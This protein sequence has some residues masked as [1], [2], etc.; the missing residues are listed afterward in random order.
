MG[1]IGH[2]LGGGQCGL[3]G[4]GVAQRLQ[5]VGQCL[6]AHGNQTV[7]RLALDLLVI[8]RVG[9]VLGKQVCCAAHGGGVVVLDLPALDGPHTVHVEQQ[10]HTGILQQSAVHGVRKGRARGIHR[11]E[12][13]R[14]ELL[15]AVILGQI[16]VVAAQRLGQVGVLC[17]LGAND[18]GVEVRPQVPVAEA[19][20][21]AVIVHIKG[22]AHR[23]GVARGIAGLA[24]I[25]PG[26][27]LTVA[28]PAARDGYAVVDKVHRRQQVPKVDALSV[29]QD[30]GV[31]IL[32]RRQLGVTAVDAALKPGVAHTG[33]QLPDRGIVLPR[34]GVG[35]RQL[36]RVG[37]VGLIGRVLPRQ[38]LQAGQAV[39][40]RVVVL[41]MGW[42][43]RRAEQPQ[44]HKQH[45][46]Q[47]GHTVRY[48]IR[49]QAPPVKQD[50]SR[51][52]A[53]PAPR[54]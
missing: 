10:L 7:I 24:V 3:S 8:D 15:D 48:R 33:G 35:Q 29:G 32:Q 4:V 22:S 49:S 43:C 40:H 18:D 2:L 12:A 54:V 45:S 1:V 21:R 44:Q 47:A 6:P 52:K 51:G 30:D 53:A 34:A 25:L 20:Q 37:R 46:Q 27:L 41:R 36:D 42:Q 38:R 16:R 39:Q 5:R 26:Q 28:A 13:Q 31:H 17:H 14:D 19:A 11:A 9:Q 50:K 23:L